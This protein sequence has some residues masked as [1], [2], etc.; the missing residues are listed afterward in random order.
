VILEQAPAVEVSEIERS[1]VAPWVLSG[2]SQEALQDQAARLLSHVDGVDAADVAFS[3]V[4][5]R[6]AFDRR[7]VVF[8]EDA[9]R[10]LAAGQA[11]PGV[12]TG[13]AVDGSTAFMFSGQ[14]SQ[15][16]GMG[17]GLYETFPC[18][19]TRWTRCVRTSTLSWTVRCVR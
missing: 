8:G 2:V 13:A 4:S 11:S 6:S 9:L 3:L 14:G 19:R 1:V 16:V 15:R 17:K 5:S 10:A 18:S 7:A 12:V